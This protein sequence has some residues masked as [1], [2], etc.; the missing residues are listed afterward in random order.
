MDPCPSRDFAVFE[1][2][3]SGTNCGVNARNAM[4]VIVL[5]NMKYVV[6]SQCN[7]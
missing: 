3:G 7:M 2:D 6:D 1:V 5:E 4:H